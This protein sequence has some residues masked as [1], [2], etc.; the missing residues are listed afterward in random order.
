MD[1]SAAV[2]VTCIYQTREWPIIG[3]AY[4][5]SSNAAE[6]RQPNEVLGKVHGIFPNGVTEDD[7]KVIYV[8]GTVFHYFPKGF[9]KSFKNIEAIQ[10]A[11]S[12]L[13]VITRSDLEPFKKLRAI[14]INDNRL[15]SLD[16]DLFQFNPKLKL[17]HFGDNRIR[18]IPEDIFDPI[19]ELNDVYL[20]NNICIS[21]DEIG[22]VQV[23]KLEAEVMKNCQP[24]KR[25][26][27]SCA[28]KDK[29]IAQL[30]NEIF[31]E[32]KKVKE[33]RTKVVELFNF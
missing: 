5:C 30:R 9:E 29:E 26:T 33:L 4:E 1:L 14:W 32:R 21:R 27:D 20:S 10:I 12:G 23:K 18:S 16:A 6:I 13:K 28:T 7:V 3:N 11:H 8:H 19:D 24:T 2:D 17:I 25:T 22:K 31:E 15:T